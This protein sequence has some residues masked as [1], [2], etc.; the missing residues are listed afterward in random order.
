[1]CALNKVKGMVGLYEDFGNNLSVIE[2]VV[3]NYSRIMIATYEQGDNYLIY[4]I[5]P[6][7]ANSCRDIK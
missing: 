4:S 5:N 2:Q 1:M 7:R 6:I 3:A